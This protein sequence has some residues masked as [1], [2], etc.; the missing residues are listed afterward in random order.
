MATKDDQICGDTQEE[1]RE[2]LIKVLTRAIILLKRKERKRKD[3]EIWVDI[4][5]EWQTKDPY[6]PARSLAKI[7]VQVLEE[8]R[9]ELL[10]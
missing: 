8:Q 1:M 9:N 6:P 4:I 3:V 7:F 5:E 2:T 10:K